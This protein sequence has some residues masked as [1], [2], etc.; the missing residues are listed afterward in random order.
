MKKKLLLLCGAFALTL[1]AIEIPIPADL[2]GWLVSNKNLVQADKEIQLSGGRSL[3]IENGAQAFKTLT[4]EKG[5]Q[6]LLRFSV[7]GE[8]LEKGARII[9][10]SP[11]VKRWYPVSSR[12]DRKEDKGTF[13]WKQ[14]SGLLDPAVLG[15][16]KVS[17]NFKNYGKGRVWFDKISLVP[18]DTKLPDGWK[19]VYGTQIS[20]GRENKL[21]EG[22]I[23]IEKSGRADKLFTLEDGVEYELTFYMKGKDIKGGVKDGAQVLIC[24]A[25]RKN[26]ARANTNSKGTP[27]KGTFDWKKGTRRFTGKYF[28][29]NKIYIM[30]SLSG[31]GTAWFDK[32]ELK[33]VGRPQGKTSF[34]NIFAP[35]IKNAAF[36]PGGIAG[37]FKPDEKITLHLELDGQGEY[38]TCVKV[39]NYSTGKEICKP[40]SSSLKAPGKMSVTI[41]GQ[42][43]GYYVAE[44]ELFRSKKKIGRIQCGIAVSP[45]FS[46]RDPFFQFGFGVYD[47]LHDAYK[48]VGAGAI[49][50]K[51]KS[52]EMEKGDP[53][54]YVDRQLKGYRSFLKSGDFVLHLSVGATLRKSS[55]PDAAASGRPVLTDR[56]VDNIIKGL[57]HAALQTRGKVKEWSVGSEIPSQATIPRYAGTWCEAMFNTMTITRMASRIVKKID[58]SVKIFYGGNNIQRYTQTIEKIVFGDLVKEVDGYFIDAY[59]GNW[60]MTRGGC[61]I[62]EQSLRSFYQEASELSAG[63]GKSYL[64]KNDETGYAINY[65]SPYD[66]GLAV[67]QAELTAR[68]FILTKAAPVVCLELHMPTFRTW[69]MTNLQDSQRWMTTIWKPVV[70]NKKIHEVPLPGGAAYAVLAHQLSF[71]KLETEFISG[72]NYACIFTKPDG[73]TVAAVWNTDN[74]VEISLS[75]PEKM[76][77]IDMVGYESPL[78]KGM[79]KLTVSPAPVYLVGR[80]QPKLLAAQLKKAFAAATPPLTAAAKRHDLKQMT[81]FVRNPGGDLADVILRGDGKILKRVKAAPGISTIQVP[82]CKNLEI[83][84]G[85]KVLPVKQDKSFIRVKH[86][87][88]KPVFD[89][90]GTWLKGLVTNK[91]RV[92]FDV[93][94]KT[95]L[96]PERAYFK[97]SFNPQGH[98]FAADW[99][100]AY[101]RDNLYIAVKADDKQHINKVKNGYLWEGDS[102]QWVL[103]GKDVPPKEI[104]PSGMDTQSCISTCNFGLGRTPQGVE[105]YRFLGK[106][107]RRNYPA[108]IT[109]K[110][111]ITFYEAAVPWKELGFRPGTGRA[112]RFS[113]VVFDK[114][115]ESENGVSYHLD[116]TR[117]V[118]GGM[119][120]GEYRLLE[121]EK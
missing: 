21:L 2:K 32:I 69:D 77:L 85:K 13:D 107:G 45:E 70:F 84:S 101:D 17:V 64:I 90:S 38:S 87:R 75:L 114:T 66:G 5:K 79:N 3:R 46:R 109:R 62:P 73:Q 83:I 65:G 40:I 59:T 58:P 97:S 31:G 27:E 43:N 50:M 94:P 15:G 12:A 113:L 26:W 51:L 117:G 41:P 49:A 6:Y 80:V 74:K 4:L 57:T 24:G 52:M 119:D 89:G 93:Y 76:Q 47:D 71:A 102:I 55:D 25:D 56:F 82:V 18:I 99:F 95:A 61:S 29:N 14:G 92:P 39:K 88:K 116:V 7:K 100:L 68:T 81:V 11:G 22:S 53:V 120:A 48:R 35:E 98:D 37:F 91:L 115:K 20:V 8:N 67:P 105:Y 86:L 108:N 1:S 110:N 60:D 111:G 118:A 10:N 9:L 30:P 36:Y 16:T 54:R 106:A 72:M 42:K 34:R 103:S 121:F 112:I 28:K 63:M 23:R 78:L 96:Q 44:A 33:K 104:R 19:N